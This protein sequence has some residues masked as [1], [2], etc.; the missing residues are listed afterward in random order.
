MQVISIYRM[1]YE[2]QFSPIAFVFRRSVLEVIGYFDQNL[3]GYGDWDFHLRFLERYDIDYLN[4]TTALAFYH[5]PPEATGDDGNSVFKDDQQVLADKMFNKWLRTDLERGQ[6]GLGYIL[7]VL[8]N[9]PIDARAADTV[10][11]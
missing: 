3:R 2:N 11:L 7:N 9:E 5:Q 4:T 8:R 1:C 10:R 6:L